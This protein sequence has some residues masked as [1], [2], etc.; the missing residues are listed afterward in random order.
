[1]RIRKLSMALLLTLVL[2]AL[3]GCAGSQTA[4]TG[5][6]ETSKARLGR[7]ELAFQPYQV[8]NFTEAK[9]I[10]ARIEMMDNPNLIGW[11]YWLSW[12]G[13]VVLHEAVKG[14]ITSSG[15]RLEPRTNN[16]SINEY[17]GGQEVVQTDGTFGS[18]DQYVYYLTVE[19]IYRQ[20]SGLYAYSTQPFVVSDQYMAA[21]EVDLELE[22]RRLQAMQALAGGQCVNQKLQ[23]VDCD[24][25]EMTGGQ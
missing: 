20:W 8:Q 25:Y 17:S 3:A 9:S 1:M 10:N 2:I 7:R 4:S 14:K 24:T 22:A 11:I 15:K 5:R 6:T 18:S 13:K 21:A 23:V 12:D 19:G 16:W